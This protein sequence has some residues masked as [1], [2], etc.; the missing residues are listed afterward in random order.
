[1][2]KILFFT[3]Q[4]R[5]QTLLVPVVFKYW[6]FSILMTNVHEILHIKVKLSELYFNNNYPYLVFIFI[7]IKW[8]TN[9][10]TVL[11]KNFHFSKDE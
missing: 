7:P 11:C 2:E 1:M 10:Q 3:I 5:K 6:K 4:L 9:L 8:C